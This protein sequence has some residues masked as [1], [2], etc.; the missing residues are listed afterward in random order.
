MT[1]H[2]IVALLAS[3]VD[4]TRVVVV[5][6][7]VAVAIA[8]SASCSAVHLFVPCNLRGD[9]EYL[10]P[11]PMPPTTPLLARSRGNLRLATD[12]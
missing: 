1:R 7:A 4:A 10:M 8:G 9:Y 3:F 5:G 6:V 2:L 12:L 11:I